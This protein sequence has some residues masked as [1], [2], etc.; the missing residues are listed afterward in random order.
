MTRPDGP[1]PD[2]FHGEG[3]GRKANEGFVRLV[4]RVDGDGSGAAVEDGAIA[5]WLGD[6]AVLHGFLGQH[7]YLG[8]NVRRSLDLV[9]GTRTWPAEPGNPLAR[10]SRLL[11]AGRLPDSYALLVGRVCEQVGAPVPLGSGRRE[12]EIRLFQDILSV[13]ATQDGVVGGAAMAE[14]LMVRSLRRLA[15]EGGATDRVAI[16]GIVETLPNLFS[17]LYFLAALARSGLG[18]RVIDDLEVLAHGLASSHA[19]IE[20]AVFRPFD[21][22]A[23]ARALA[24]AAAAFDHSEIPAQVSARVRLRIVCL[25]DA[26][27]MRGPFLALMDRAEPSMPRR[28]ESLAAVIA[29]GLVSEFGGR[30]LVEQHMA[31]I[32]V[33]PEVE[34]S[35]EP[36]APLLDTR[37]SSRFGRTRC[38]YCFEPK[39]GGFMC[40]VCG[41]DEDEG[42]RPG[43][44]LPAGTVLQGRYVIGRLIGQGGFGATYLGW[45]ERF[46]DKVAVKEYF[47]TSLAGRAADRGAIE[48][49]TDAQ[50]A[51]FR[52]GIAKFLAEAR[53]LGR[54]RHVR[55]IVEVLDHF[56]ANGTAYMVMELLVGRTLQRHLLEEGGAIDYRRALGLILPIA[57]AVHAAHGLGVLHRDIS[58]DNIF[59]GDQGAVKLL[60]FGAAR[61]SVGEAIGALPVILKRGY[62][63]PEQYR[64]D[65]DQG[66]WTDVYALS[67][68][69]YCAITGRPP[70]DSSL[71]RD[72]EPV[73][74]PSALGFTLPAA[75]EEALIAGLALRREDRP[76]D[77]KTWLSG[78][79][80]ALL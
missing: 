80:R 17:R 22:P 21:P 5:E 14:A 76:Q 16:Q 29:A 38:P 20:N 7:P 34:P 75:L 64:S 65:G 26:F 56:E 50:N 33:R 54:L 72:D 44:H 58:P 35:P 69:L 24:R 10:L 52:D 45:D 41:Y 55:E 27:V 71:R 70:Q 4:G 48:P 37:L 15:Q 49:Y 25:I 61:H 6:E 36:V 32:S 77:M 31:E 19:L 12:E 59:L 43:V 39:N 2:A 66:P 28:R 53:T 78:L 74:R 1:R 73:L 3:G 23:L 8:V 13:V 11:V 62:A 42:A 30:P 46:Q 40:L 67:A 51:T 57:K 68:T 9:L 47:P 18:R 63:P 60:D 79:N